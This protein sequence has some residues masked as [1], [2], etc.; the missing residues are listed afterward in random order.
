[1]ALEDG[2]HCLHVGGDCLSMIKAVQE[3][4]EA[5]SYANS[6]ITDTKMMLSSYSQ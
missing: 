1:M 4:S 5:I 2:F 6:L 3:K